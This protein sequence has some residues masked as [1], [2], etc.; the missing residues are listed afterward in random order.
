MHKSILAAGGP[1]FEWADWGVVAVYLVLTTVLGAKLAGRQATIRDF[2]LGGRK[3]PWWAICGSTIATE[4]STATFVTLP[5]LSFAAGGNLTYLQLAIGSILA[6]VIVAIYF[7]PRYYE[8]EIYSPYDYAGHRLGARVKTA[9]TALFM[10]GAVLGQGARLYTSGF[11]LSTVAG[12][13]LVTAIWLMGIFSVLWAMIG[14]ITMVIWTDV[15]QFFVLV[16]GALAVLWFS[17]SSIPANWG[18]MFQIAKDA[19]KFR[20]FDFSTSPA[21]TYTFW[22]GIFCTPFVNLAA[23]GTDQVMTQ[24]LFCCRNQRDATKATI[25]SSVSIFIALLMLLVG[26]GLFVYF[27]FKPFSPE[28]AALFDKR[29]TYLLPIFI[30]RA[31]PIGVRGLV[32]A[33]IFAAAVSTLES[34]LAAL[35][36]TTSGPILKRLGQLKG[37]KK[38]RKLKWL[39]SEVIIS[40]SLVCGWG[41]VLCL[42]A[43]ACLLMENRFANTIDLVLSMSGYTVGPLLGIFLLAFLP[44]PPSDVGLPWAVPLAVLAVFGMLQHEWSFRFIGDTRVDVTDLIV[45]GG[46]IAALVLTLKHLHGDVRKVGVVAIAVI[47]IVLLHAWNVGIDTSGKTLYPSYAWSYSV[48]PLLTMGLGY[49]LGLPGPSPVRKSNKRK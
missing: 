14:G 5:A 44:K 25:V 34:A 43:S 32:V 21:V 47:A 9:T 49:V 42:M 20:L 24:R 27:R 15:I 33:A 36:Q 6:R 4:V 16:L 3:L 17:Y 38:S 1:V 7:V 31:L 23:F 11:V 41:V 39:Q 26:I 40:K 13:D 30:V 48:G 19:D 22:V 29:N 37:K 2:F 12:V 8:K 10:I 45:W 46:S 35:A 28:E 18:D